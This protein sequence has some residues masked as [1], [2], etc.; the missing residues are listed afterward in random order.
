MYRAR[1]IAGAYYRGMLQG[2]TM[3]RSHT[4]RSVQA[5]FTLYAAS[6]VGRPSC[7]RT[8]SHLQPSL[9]PHLTTDDGHRKNVV[10]KG[11][12]ATFAD[13]SD[14]LGVTKGS[15]SRRQ[16]IDTNRTS[17]HVRFN[18]SGLQF[19]K[20]LVLSP[21]FFDQDAVI[22]FGGHVSSALELE[23]PTYTSADGASVFTL[24]HGEVRYDIAFLLCPL[25]G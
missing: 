22:W 20:V 17:I 8:A 5:L 6:L 3:R 12:T 24:G 16:V 18:T 19:D 15:R 25:K 2:E 14:A 1:T 21:S 4:K 23:P 11:F 13:G 7:A 9:H 10:V